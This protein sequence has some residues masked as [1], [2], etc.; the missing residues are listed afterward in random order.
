MITINKD[1]C[2]ACGQCVKD[3]VSGNLEIKDKKANVKRDTCLL[4]GHCIAICPEDAVAMDDY[5][6][7]DVREYQK[8]DF[9]I[10]PETLLNF[11]KFRRSIRRFRKESVEDEKLLKIIEAGR[12]TP[13]G[14]NRQDVRYIVVRDKL[15]ELRRLALE[16]LSGVLAEQAK[17]NP[18]LAALASRWA[19]MYESDREQQGKNDSLF[20]NAPVVILLVSDSP[21]DASLA[22]ANMELMSA[23][24]GLGAFYCGFFM[25]AAQGDDKIKELLG[26]GENQEI[27]VAL[28]IGKTDVTY[29]RTVPRKPSVIS[30]K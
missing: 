27:R 26:L 1:K 29:K 23:A 2:I 14:S 3:C 30:W 22:A 12:F 8:E 13:T 24:Q 5:P 19:N 28:V 21:V 17:E 10:E 18:G 20:Y 11:I 4:C 6:M 25:R 15:P 16:K 9:M 7:A